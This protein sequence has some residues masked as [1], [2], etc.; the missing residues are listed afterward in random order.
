VC[1]EP[2]GIRRSK[3]FTLIEVLVVMSIMALL[4]TAV[5]I[6]IAALPGA[7]LRAAADDMADRLK[8]LHG[9]ALRRGAT[10][11]LTFDLG[12]RSFRISTDPVPHK[13]AGV[14]DRVELKTP[15]ALRPDQTAG[16][17]FFAD[18]TYKQT[19]VIM[20]LRPFADA[21]GFFQSSFPRITTRRTRRAAAK[22]RRSR[23][24]ARYQ[25]NG[26]SREVGR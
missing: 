1:R 24:F 11:A 18:G 23:V 6:M 14:V 12:A 25:K 16:I 9:E 13:L 2:A 21:R 19:R 3:G 4:M 26:G 15:T 8:G 10:M 17:R 5:P 22:T 7:Q 20:R